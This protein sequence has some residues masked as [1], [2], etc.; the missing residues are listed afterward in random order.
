[1]SIGG[2]GVDTDKASWPCVLSQYHGM[3]R[4]HWLT[5]CC[6]WRVWHCAMVQGAREACLQFLLHFYT[7]TSLLLLPCH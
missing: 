7:S 5:V 1:M 6:R 3:T 2:E 4:C